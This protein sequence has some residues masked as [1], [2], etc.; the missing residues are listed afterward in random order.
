MRIKGVYCVIC[1]SFGKDGSSES[2]SRIEECKMSESNESN[3][4][5]QMSQI[6]RNEGRVKRVQLKG[7]QRRGPKASPIRNRAKLKNSC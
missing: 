7:I 4:S 6:S 5:N 2:I 3:E 1:Q